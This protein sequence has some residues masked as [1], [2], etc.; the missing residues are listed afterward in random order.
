[1]LIKS[2]QRYVGPFQRRTERVVV[3]PAAC[4][5]YFCRQYWPIWPAWRTTF[6]T[7][8]PTSPGPPSNP[9]DCKTNHLT[10]S[11][12]LDIFNK[13]RRQNPMAAAPTFSN[14]LQPIYIVKAIWLQ[15]FGYRIL[16]GASGYEFRRLPE[17]TKVACFFSSILSWECLPLPRMQCSCWFMAGGP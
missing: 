11:N 13:G 16:A 8:A 2:N 7:H 3:W 15:H 10:V 14:Q 4:G 12:I 6:R 9:P 1:M 5:A 17:L